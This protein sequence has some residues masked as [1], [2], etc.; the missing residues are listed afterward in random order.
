[1]SLRLV[2]LTD[3]VAPVKCLQD[4]GDIRIRNSILNLDFNPPSC[5]LDA[6]SRRAPIFHCKP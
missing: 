6:S 3:T 4:Y 1:V 2:D 5:D